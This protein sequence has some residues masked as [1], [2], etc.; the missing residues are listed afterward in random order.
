MSPLQHLLLD[1]SKTEKEKKMEKK[2]RLF[3]LSEGG[4]GAY[5]LSAKATQTVKA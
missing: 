5:K 1:K 2:S 3:L 4:T